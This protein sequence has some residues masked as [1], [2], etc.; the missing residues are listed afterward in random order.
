MKYIK[1][2]MSIFSD[3]FDR[4]IFLKMNQEKFGRLKQEKFLHRSNE[5]IFI[6]VFSKQIFSL[7]KCKTNY[8]LWY[9]QY[10]LVTL[11]KKYSCNSFTCGIGR[12]FA[13]ILAPSG[14]HFLAPSALLFSSLFDALRGLVPSG[15]CPTCPLGRKVSGHRFMLLLSTTHVSYIKWET[16]PQT[17]IK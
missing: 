8:S 1:C 2:E 16:Q 12:N 15:D 7:E 10:P 9:L 3:N 5:K 14:Y 11:S 17:N 4:K 6:Q 13:C